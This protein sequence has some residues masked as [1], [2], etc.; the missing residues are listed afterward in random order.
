ME[1]D[2]GDIEAMSEEERYAYIEAMSE[3]ERY[4]YLEAMSEEE[5]EAYFISTFEEEVEAD[6]ELRTDLDEHFEKGRYERMKEIASEFFEKG[7]PGMFWDAFIVPAL[8]AAG[9]PI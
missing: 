6:E 4:A 7:W 1:I 5:R 3:E 8:R 9:F 2:K